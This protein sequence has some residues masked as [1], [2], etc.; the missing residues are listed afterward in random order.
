MPPVIPFVVAGLATVGIVGLPATVIANVVAIALSVGASFGLGAVSK[1]IAGK[2]KQNGSL[3]ALQDRTQAVR[4][5]ITARRVIY[6]GPVRVSGVYTF[7][8]STDSNQY[9]NLLLTLSG[10]LIQS[11]DSVYFGDELIPLDSNGNATGKYAGYVIIKKGLGSTAGDADLLSAMMS[12][13]PGVWT[14]N[15]RQSGCGKLYARLKYS[16]TLFP[17]GIPNISCIVKGKLVLDPRTGLIEW[18]NNAALCVRNYLKDSTYGLGE[19]NVNDTVASASANVCD[20]SVGTLTRVGDFT[21]YQI[22]APT[23]API[24]KQ[25]LVSIPAGVPAA[26][27]YKYAFTF[28]DA[29]G[30]TVPGPQ[31]TWS[32][33]PAIWGVSL[34]GISKGPTGTIARKI[35]RT[36]AGGSQLK[37][38][39][40]LSDNTTSEYADAIPDGSLGANAPTS[41]STAVYDDIRVT[42]S[43]IVLSTGEAVALTTTGT[44]PAGL[45]AA[46]YYVIDTGNGSY[47]LATSKANA[48]AGTYVN[49]TGLGSGT[50]TLNSA[51]EVR[52]TCNGTFDTDEKPKDI[53]GKL[54]TS[55]Q[56]KVTYQG[57]EWIILP[58][59][60][61][62]PTIT[63]DENDLDGPIKVTSRISRSQT[64]NAVKGVYINPLDFYQPNDFPP[65][66]NATYLAEDQGERIWKDI[67]LP[68]TTSG[69]MAQ[70]IA[71]IELEKARQQIT[72]T[73]PC[74]L[75]AF[76]VQAG[77]VVNLSNTRWGWNAK[78]F[79][80]TNWKFA[81][82]DDNGIPRLGID[83]VLRE[84]ASG[85]YDW[86]S[87]EETAIDLAP[88]TT[89]P[90]PFTVQ[91]PG[92]PSVTEELYQTTGSAGV[93]SKAIVTWG[94]SADGFADSYQL[95]YK[96][97]TQAN[98]LVRTGIKGFETELTDLAP[99]Y[100]D[101][102][103][104]AFNSIGVDSDYTNEV[105][106]QLVGLSAP[107]AD[108]SGFSVIASNGYAL[109]SWALSPDLDVQINGS[110][111]IRHSSKTSGAVWEDGIILEEF[112]GGAV[113]GI[114]ALITGTYMAKAKDSTGNY[115]TSM[116]PFVATEGMTTGFTT[117]ATST[118]APGFTGTKTNVS[119]VGSVLRLTDP[120]ANLEGEYEFD[121]PVDM[122]TVETRRV[123]V[124][125]QVL[126][127][128]ANDLI[129]SMGEVDSWASIDGDSVDDCD[130]TVYVA[131]TNDDPSGSPV[132]GPWIPFMVADLT[133]RAMKFK[134]KLQS[135]STTNNLDVSV[136]TVHVKEAV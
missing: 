34:S 77:D 101:F 100:Y 134:I 104:K 25:N 95:E 120:E 90:D 57:G 131:T 29:S 113:Q 117:V 84:T 86:S 70:R 110:V 121:N 42:G 78:P 116:T 6:G 127:Y 24:T 115:S 11:I 49:I 112:P 40:T 66:T 82:R 124:D 50:H 12:Y 26:G 9:I 83:L 135:G 89:L 105:R 109:A 33:N 1:A 37:L 133:C 54:L 136:L 32:Q 14:S 56:G 126:N 63:L 93:K 27:V 39:A 8:H 67:E 28:V 61:R 74:K 72:T 88:N 94:A 129:D 46:T 22:P 128:V 58:G 125:V 43:K 59:A 103:L 31:T 132:Y 80:V 85:V 99:G 91:V 41:T 76:R 87:G 38:L 98:W 20:E 96:P 21:V 62:S 73:W 13:C 130:A 108:I 44:L 69:S 17:N 97:A 119:L 111:I 7:I 4:Q 2:P 114:V 3:G 122:G 23:A 51:S 64:F 68:F 55:M 81:I 107:P 15:H 19:S 35:Y 92:D 123:E 10:H 47:Y 18:S 106:V 118:Q 71:K 45:S 52:Y 36:A 53:I 5:P 65:I 102:R 79:E 16:T 48:L 75:T 30:E 60:Y